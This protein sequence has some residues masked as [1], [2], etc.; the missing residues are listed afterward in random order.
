VKTFITRIQKRA[1][2]KAKE[3]AE[4]RARKKAAGEEDDE[5]VVELSK[6]ERLGPG[7]LDPVEVFESLPEAMKEAFES[8]E[9]QKLQVSCVRI[10][11]LYCNPLLHQA[12]AFR[13][14]FLEQDALSS[15]PPEEA[16]YHMKR[17][18]ESGL[19]V[20]NS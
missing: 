5:E 10:F 18:E 11:V 2:D 3:M 9:V 4:E 6:E 7:G 12:F 14:I 1:V 8:Q 19:W 13:F 16:K 15:L 17:C 20:T